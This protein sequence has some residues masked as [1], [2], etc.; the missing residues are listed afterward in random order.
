MTGFSHPESLRAALDAWERG[1]YGAA[2]DTFAPWLPLV[3]FEAQPG[4][5]LSLRKTIL[6]ERGVFSDAAVR[7]PSRSAPQEI[8]GLMADHLTA[9]A[10]SSPPP[11]PTT[12]GADMD[13]GLAGRTVLIPGSTSGLG[14]AS[15]RAFAAEGAN[16]VVTGR[17]GDVAAT[18]AAALP[19]AIGVEIDLTEP[20]AASR[21]VE[22]THEAFGP[23]DVLVLNSGGPPPGTATDT[24]PAAVE[25][26]LQTLLLQQLRLVQAVL[27]SMRKGGWGRIV[28]IGSSGVQQPLEMLTLSNT[29]RAALSG[30]LKTL[31]AEVAADGVTVNMVLPGRIDTERVAALDESKADRSGRSAAEV[32]SA[33]EATIPAGRY[34]RP[35]EFAAAVVFLASGAASY[36]T[37]TQLRVDGGLVRSF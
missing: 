13:T 10:A 33:A 24:T 6:R 12:N 7:P 21:L 3:N 8:L 18:E 4:I 30:Y 14:L 29:G 31:A 20:D 26:A 19:S 2:R 15:A 22:Q 17:R 5:G 25:S 34:G 36:I 9:P 1:G 37:G 35:E 23:V 16:V 32:R 11:T 28:A 27:P